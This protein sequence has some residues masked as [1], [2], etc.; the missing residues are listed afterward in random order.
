MPTLCPFLERHSTY[1]VVTCGHSLGAGVAALLA[2]YLHHSTLASSLSLVSS[3]PLAAEKPPNPFVRTVCH[4]FACP[5]VVSSALS[6]YMRPFCQTYVC[7]YDIIPRFHYE[8]RE[9]RQ[10]ERETVDEYKSVQLGSLLGRPRFSVYEASD[11]SFDEIYVDREFWVH[12]QHFAYY[13]ATKHTM[14]ASSSRRS[15]IG[16]TPVPVSVPVL[17]TG[18]EEG[19]EASDA[20]REIL[21]LHANE[22]ESVDEIGGGVTDA[23]DESAELARELFGN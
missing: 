4:A 10:K 20:E 12:H 7:Q 2:L 3:A 17:S 9:E 13:Y 23:L 11:E 5:A 1:R 16:E 15:S 21:S 8:D 18:Y 6:R 14:S 22:R 19:S